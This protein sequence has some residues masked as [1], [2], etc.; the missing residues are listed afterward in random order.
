MH[1]LLLPIFIQ[2]FWFFWWMQQ[3]TRT[4]CISWCCLYY[5]KEVNVLWLQSSQHTKC[6]FFWEKKTQTSPSYL[7]FE[8]PIRISLSRKTIPVALSLARIMCIL[9]YFSFV[10]IIP[11]SLDIAFS[12][13]NLSWYVWFR[14]IF[15]AN[16]WKFSNHFF[17]DVFVG[18]TKSRCPI[19]CHFLF[20]AVGYS[21]LSLSVSISFILLSSTFSN[22][23][24]CP[25]S[26]LAI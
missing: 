10:V 23:H 19:S 24:C 5:E 7:G 18:K 9:L 11:N 26:L 21:S 1:A 6:C 17:T 20:I 16:K 2:K 15:I 25:N 12:S 13:P 14:H 8:L 4:H 22:N 3:T